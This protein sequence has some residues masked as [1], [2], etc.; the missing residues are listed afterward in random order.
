M[1]ETSFEPPLNTSEQ[2]R[3]VGYQISEVFFVFILTTF[4]HLNR[5]VVQ[6]LTKLSEMN[7]LI[8]F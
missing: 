7:E 5:R 4:V 8:S 2:Y 3:N 1:Y 6:N